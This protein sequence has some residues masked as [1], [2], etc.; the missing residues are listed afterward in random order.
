MPSRF[1]HDDLAA[2]LGQ[3]PGDRKADHAGADDDAIDLIH[4]RFRS[5]NLARDWAARRAPLYYRF[6][7]S[8]CPNKPLD[9]LD[10]RSEPRR[11]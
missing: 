5:G 7:K 3:P 6:V 9:C 4:V 11:R 8:V 2:G 1:E 10:I